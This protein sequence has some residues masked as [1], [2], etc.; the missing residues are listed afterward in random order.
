MIKFNSPFLSKYPLQKT[1]LTGATNRNSAS[2]EGGGGEEEEAEYDDDNDDEETEIEL[3]YRKKEREKD[4]SEVEG[5]RDTGARVRPA[6]IWTA[7]VGGG[8][9]G[10]R[11]GAEEA[12]DRYIRPGQRAVAGSG[13]RCRADRLIKFVRH[14]AKY[15]RLSHSMP[16]TSFGVTIC[17]R[18]LSLFPRFKCQSL[19]EQGSKDE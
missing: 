3:E 1:K 11:A 12:G 2:V 10:G 18:L 7:A 4:G 9:G 15:K 13:G 17:R 16:I 6:M 14:N 19:E 8:H 5:G